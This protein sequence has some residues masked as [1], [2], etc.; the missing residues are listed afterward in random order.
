MERFINLGYNHYKMTSEKLKGLLVGVAV[1]VMAYT[2][3]A[4]TLSL[5]NNIFN[6][7]QEI[8]ASGIERKILKETKVP[9][10]TKKIE[11][12][13]IPLISGDYTDIMLN[14]DGVGTSL[15]YRN[16]ELE[17]K[18]AEKF[19]TEKTKAESD[20]YDRIREINEN[21]EKMIEKTDEAKKT[22]EWET[23]PIIESNEEKVE[24]SEQR[25]QNRTKYE[26]LMSRLFG[27]KK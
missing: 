11:Y 4:G 5:Y 8:N 26:E 17:K 22:L 7:N 6:S 18:L 27:E 24:S 25:H 13:S 20:N 3:T 16:S 9:L 15:A 12:I 21:Y 1:G 23:K 14:E 2:V 10:L 19:E